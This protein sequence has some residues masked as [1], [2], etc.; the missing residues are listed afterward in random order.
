MIERPCCNH[1]D[2]TTCKLYRDT[3]NGPGFFHKGDKGDTG[4]GVEGPMGPQGERGPKGDQGIQGVPGPQGIQGIRGPKGDPGIQGPKGDVG[5]A[6]PI[7]P[8]GIQGPI[9]PQGFKGIRGP[10]G[11][12]GPQ[13]PKGDQGIQGPPGAASL[14]IQDDVTG[15]DTTWSST[16]I[17]AEHATI[18]QSVATLESSATQSISNINSSI[19]TINNSLSNIN[20]VVLPA[21]INYTDLTPITTTGTD[22]AYTATIPANVTEVTIV[23]HINNLAGATLNDVPIL[24][25]E[26]AP[27]KAATLKVDIPTKLV[28]VGS[29]FFIASGGS[30]VLKIPYDQSKFKNF[31]ILNV[32]NAG[33]SSTADTSEAIYDSTNSRFISIFKLLSEIKVLHF[34]SDNLYMYDKKYSLTPLG[35]MAGIGGCC[36]LDGLVYIIDSGDIL[37]GGAHLTVYNPSDGSMVSCTRH[38]NLQYRQYN[39]EAMANGMVYVNNSGNKTLIAFNL[40]TKTYNTYT[41]IKDSVYAMDFRIMAADNSSYVYMLESK[42]LS[43][44]NPSDFSNIFTTT[45]AYTGTLE[46][47]AVYKDV[48]HVLTSGADGAKLYRFS[49]IDGSLIDE[50]L[51]TEIKTWTGLKLSV[52][53]GYYIITSVN[54]TRVVKKGTSTILSKSILRFKVLDDEKLYCSF[55]NNEGG[56]TYYSYHMASLNVE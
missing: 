27:I 54:G 7:G 17:T 31:R 12:E 47:T 15:P 30:G 13:G 45:I 56:S 41:I 32:Y 4:V 11:P 18:T 48:V 19:E 5:P 23:P 44:Y 35:A 3:C 16:K 36:M 33:F 9:G 1:Y 14:S 25:R 10:V 28:R 21:K 52:T 8:Q 55:N 46:S 6:G 22:S 20:D 39:F 38:G 37:N 34:S 26:G 51:I 42:K 53:E 49:P 24:D 50:I 40:R 43:K 2:C 29:N